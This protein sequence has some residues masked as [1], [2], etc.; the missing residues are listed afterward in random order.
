MSTLYLIR[1]AQASFGADDYD[2]LSPLGEEQSRVLGAHVAERG[3]KL[4][5]VFTGPRKRQVDT[6]S[7]MRGTANERGGSIPE[8]VELPELDEYPAFDLF[9]KWLP[10]LITDDPQLSGAM[11]AT[12][13][14]RRRLMERAIEL[15]SLKWARGE[16]DTGDLETFAAFDQRVNDGLSA[17]MSRLGRG[18][19]AALVTSGG[20]ISVTMRRALTLAEDT[21]LRVAWVIANASISEFRFRD[22]DFSLISFNGLPHFFERRLFTYR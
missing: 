1:H 4:D 9:K 15:V 18:K 8:P 16:L 20:P 6:A 14:E 19:R 12:G 13:A 2:V 17:V 11:A 5:A 10:R 3:M 22:D 21:T 7:L